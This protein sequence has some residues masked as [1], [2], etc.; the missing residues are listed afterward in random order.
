VQIEIK[1]DYR[2]KCVKK[3]YLYM[4]KSPQHY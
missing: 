1:M 3:F 4:E 2:A